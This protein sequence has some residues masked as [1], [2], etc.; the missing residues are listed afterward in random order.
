MKLIELQTVT[1]E[2]KKAL[3]AIGKKL[4]TWKDLR[5]DHKKTG[6]MRFSQQIPISDRTFTEKDVAAFRKR[7]KVRHVKT[8]SDL[9]KVMKGTRES[10]IKQ[11]NSDFDDII[12]I[13]SPFHGDATLFDN[14]DEFILQVD[15]GAML[16]L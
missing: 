8:P 14:G 9:A 12:S 15:I 2:A 13:V 1:P 11:F 5:S 7:E 16:I 10:M 6:Y 3:Q 4:S